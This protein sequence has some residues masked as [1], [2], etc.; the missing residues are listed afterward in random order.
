MERAMI[1]FEH[2]LS[3]YSQKVKIALREKGLPF[4]LRVPDGLGSGAGC[5][6]LRLRERRARRARREVRKFDIARCSSGCC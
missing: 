5:A 1:L 6:V 2:P 3:P 4:E